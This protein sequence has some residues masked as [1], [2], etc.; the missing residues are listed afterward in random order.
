MG[1][2][3]GIACLL[4]IAGLSFGQAIYQGIA[5]KLLE[6]DSQ[7]ILVPITRQM[8]TS[9]GINFGWLYDHGLVATNS[10]GFATS[11]ADFET[12]AN[13]DYDLDGLSNGEEYIA[14]TN[15]KVS[16]GLEGVLNVVSNGVEVSTSPAVAERVYDVSFKTNL[17]D[18]AWMPAGS[19][20]NNVGETDGF[21]LDTNGLDCSFYKV[22]VSLP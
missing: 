8:K 2:K 4:G 14:G 18:G 9:Q 11:S 22:K 15:P 1:S 3:A 6:T 10:Q 20:T 21:L 16:D 13:A 17:M 7:Q 5:S 12:A 19:Y